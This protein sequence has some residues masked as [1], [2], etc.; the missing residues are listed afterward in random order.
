[1]KG[2]G[3]QKGGG[4]SANEQDQDPESSS[5]NNEDDDDNYLNDDEFHDA[6]EDV[7]QFSVTLPRSKGLHQRNPSNISKLYLEESDDD[8]DNDEYES[9]TIKVTM[10]SST[11]NKDN[12]NS[13]N[14]KAQQENNQ[15]SSNTCRY[16]VNIS[17]KYF[18]F[19]LSYK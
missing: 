4:A 5:N 9:Q 17:Y 13:T 2:K 14:N 12:E 10:H 3:D 18:F 8:T 15:Q 11:N 6:V 1:V 16:I 19:K 7:T